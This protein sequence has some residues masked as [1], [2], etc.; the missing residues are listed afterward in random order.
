MCHDGSLGAANPVGEHGVG[1]HEQQQQDGRRDQG[2][3]ARADDEEGAHPGW[4]R[5]QRAGPRKE[6]GGQLTQQRQQLLA[7]VRRNGIQAGGTDAQDGAYRELIET[8][9]EDAP[10]GAREFEHRKPARSK[11]P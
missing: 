9:G 7:G 3:Q 11:H 2:E 4:V 10:D 1:E 8:E 6:G 5:A